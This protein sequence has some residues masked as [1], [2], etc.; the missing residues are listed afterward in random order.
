[1]DMRRRRHRETAILDS[2]KCGI[3]RRE[4][5]D[6]ECCCRG[7]LS[8]TQCH[9][10][11]IGKQGSMERVAQSDREGATF[12]TLTRKIVL[13]MNVMPTE[14][15]GRRSSQVRR[16][17]GRNSEVN[18]SNPQRKSV[19]SMNHSSDTRKNWIA[20]TQRP[21]ADLGSE[22][23]YSKPENACLAEGRAY[24]F[25]SWLSRAM[26]LRACREWLAIISLRG[27][28]LMWGCH[29]GFP[30]QVLALSLLRRYDAL[31]AFDIFECFVFFACYASSCIDS[32]VRC[33]SLLMWPYQ[34]SFPPMWPSARDPVGFSSNPVQFSASLAIRAPISL[35][36][37]FHGGFAGLVM[38]VLALRVLGPR[39]LPRWPLL[40]RLARLVAVPTVRRFR[41]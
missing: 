22:R 20:N 33:G 34:P 38:N 29:V 4:A 1:M 7:L 12:R 13:A 8:R 11:H 30:T 26:V 24:D 16:P 6:A 31:D 3:C 2:F 10:S 18:L 36:F 27:S 25:S 21:T 28:L 37:L 5:A 23:L 15:I 17:F 32:F 35:L 19:L 39:A 41:S 40:A 9:R 14:L